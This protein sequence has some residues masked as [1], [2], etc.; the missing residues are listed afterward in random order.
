MERKKI[1]VERER[2]RAEWIRYPVSTTLWRFGP[3]KGANENGS[4]KERI[5]VPIDKRIIRRG[6]P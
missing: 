3:A 5:F 1:R 4:N 2:K 6:V